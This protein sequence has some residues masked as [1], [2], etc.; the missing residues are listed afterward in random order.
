MH[1]LM[2]RTL[3]HGFFR[4]TKCLAGPCSPNCGVAQIQL[5]VCFF[6]S[7]IFLNYLYMHVIAH[8]S[9]DDWSLEEDVRFPEVAVTGGCT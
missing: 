7:F 8:R 5:W 9:A 6:F 1:L 2:L 3:G 4:T